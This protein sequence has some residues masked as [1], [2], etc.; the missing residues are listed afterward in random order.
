MLRTL[1][2]WLVFLG[3]FGVEVGI[4]RFLRMR[5]G[6]VTTGGIPEPLWFAIPI[7]L[8]LVS[9]FLAWQGT[10]P[11]HA[12]WKRLAVISVE[13]VVGFV[14]YAGAC[15]WYVVGSGIDSL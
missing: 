14:I 8:A 11:L 5:N 15:L 2:A 10:R 13:L 4:D 7:V 6:D 3:G 9:V 12:V 1:I